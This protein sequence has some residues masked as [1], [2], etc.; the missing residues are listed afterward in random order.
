VLLYKREPRHRPAP[1]FR[2]HPIQAMVLALCDGTRSAEEITTILAAVLR[3]A[4]QEA[5]VLFNAISE[6]YRQFLV[7]SDGTAVANRV[8]PAGLLFP[9][10]HDILSIRDAAPAGLMWVVTECCDKKCSY[11]YKD[12]FFVPDGR[13]TD[14]VLSGERM[15][16]LI[17]EAAEIGITN[18]LLTGGEP[19]LRP[20]MAE[21]IGVMVAH[22]MEV[23][24]LTKNRITGER[25]RALV[26]SGVKVIEVS[27]DSYRPAIVD[28]LT[29]VAGSFGG[30]VDTLGAAAQHGLPARLRPVLTSHNV[31]DFE[32]LVA[33]ASELGVGE[34]VVD[35]YGDSCGRTDDSFKVK[36]EDVQWV[37]S[38]AVEL[39]QRFPRTTVEL[40]HDRVGALVKL[41][42]RGCMEG[43]RGMTILP[44]GQVTKCEHWRFGDELTYGDL[45]RQSIMEVWQS[46]RL[47]QINCAPREAYAG[48]VCARCKKF[49]QCHERRGRCT[50]S[51]LRHYGKLYAPDVY[52]PIGVFRRR[53]HAASA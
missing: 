9:T 4:P 33:L 47:A 3:R 8:D 49:T 12:A 48:T 34:V 7:E 30:M 13:A 22:G 53:E 18:V 2:L 11:C 39:A 20:D 1:L 36:P 43:S 10:G 27:L 52:C 16:E 28:F 46:E 15:A 26:R 40:R 42:G 25:M 51:S 41:N 6:R 29:G 24:P 50:L 31:R 32:G 19:F 35:F 44:D 23:V 17:D 21:L 5:Q 14:L 37:R 38:K 45:R